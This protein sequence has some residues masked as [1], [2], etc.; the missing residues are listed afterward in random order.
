MSVPLNFEQLLSV[1]QSIDGI[2]VPANSRPPR[3]ANQLETKRPL[4]PA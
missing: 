1:E 3:L 4:N 2:I